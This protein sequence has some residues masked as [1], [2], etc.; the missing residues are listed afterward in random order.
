[1][2]VPPGGGLPALIDIVATSKFGR[3]ERVSPN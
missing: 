2:F 1:M 3:P